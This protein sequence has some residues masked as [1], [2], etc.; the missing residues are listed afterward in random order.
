MINH[1]HLIFM[2]PR[3]RAKLIIMIRA[4]ATLK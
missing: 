3:Q 2:G 1:S 4:K